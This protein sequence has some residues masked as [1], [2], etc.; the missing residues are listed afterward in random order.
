MTYAMRGYYRMLFLQE[1]K[2]WK[3]VAEKYPP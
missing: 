2:S 3:D 1:L